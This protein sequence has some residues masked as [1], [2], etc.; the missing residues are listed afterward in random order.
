MIPPR[1][2]QPVEGKLEYNVGFIVRSH[3]CYVFWGSVY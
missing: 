1:F 2:W 3:L